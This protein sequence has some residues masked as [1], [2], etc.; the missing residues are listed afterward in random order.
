M[1]A[2]VPWLKGAFPS[3]Q[4]RL[5]PHD[6]GHLRSC[7][8]PTLVRARA[9]PRPR[10][11]RCLSRSAGRSIS[12]RNGWAN[13]A[14]CSGPA[15]VHS[16]PDGI[17]DIGRGWS[18]RLKHK[19]DCNTTPFRTQS[20]VGRYRLLICYRPLHITSGAL[21][22]CAF[23]PQAVKHVESG[24]GR[25]HR[26]RVCL[27]QTSTGPC[28]G[29][30]AGT[31]NGQLRR[32]FP[33]PQFDA[34]TTSTSAVLYLIGSHRWPLPFLHSNPPPAKVWCSPAIGVCATGQLHRGT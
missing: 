13:R 29:E 12:R 5:L 15:T 32:C 6:A 26:Q 14:P 9:V 28:S 18:P 30:R 24:R 21:V 19:V 10:Y 4:L 2:S 7:H 33:P 23:R 17:G 34:C 31:A 16:P 27:A 20:N 3:S 11:L 8:A 25:G 22:T 1:A